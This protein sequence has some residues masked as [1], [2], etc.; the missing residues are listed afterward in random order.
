MPRVDDLLTQLAGATTFS[1]FDSN[2]DIWQIPLNEDS[3]LLTT[4][5]TLFGRC[6]KKL[7]F[8]ISSAPEIVQRRMSQMLEGMDGVLCHMDDV[9]V[10]EIA[11]PGST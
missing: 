1:K 5:V 8:G 3:Q 11:R 10:L 4:F 9:L 7:P 2:S 6:F